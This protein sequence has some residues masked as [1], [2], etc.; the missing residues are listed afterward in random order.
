MNKLRQWK[1]KAG[2]RVDEIQEKVRAQWLAFNPREKMI[3]S[4][5]AGV[6]GF[7][8]VT[9]VLKETIGLFSKVSSE[10]ETN[11]KNI[12]RLQSLLKDLQQQKT[13][14]SRYDRLRGKRGETFQFQGFLESEA[15][16]FGAVVQKV[17]PV[18]AIT[19]SEKEKPTE[20]WMEVQLKDTSLDSMLKF[21]SSVEDTL[22]LRLVE[23]KVKPQFADATKLD[24]TAIIASSKNL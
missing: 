3:V 22:G 11:F 20:E 18:R 16:K 1:E 14:L 24:I 15:A 17:S 6:M 8:V 21:L 10:A 5:L 13:D 23:L 4:I 9:L 7:L 19:G 12:E 2:E